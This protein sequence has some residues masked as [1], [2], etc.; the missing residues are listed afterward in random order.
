MCVRACPRARA[1]V[2]V[3]KVKDAM[4]GVGFQMTAR[5]QPSVNGR[6]KGKYLIDR[7]G[8]RKR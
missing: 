3:Q 8:E 4:T 5:T 2:C 6:M 1:R 7:A